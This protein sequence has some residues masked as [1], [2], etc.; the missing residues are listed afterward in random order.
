[1]K[2]VSY[3]HPKTIQIA[4]KNMFDNKIDKVVLG[5]ASLNSE[6]TA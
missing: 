2:F 4:H 1:M 3:G 5:S 6:D